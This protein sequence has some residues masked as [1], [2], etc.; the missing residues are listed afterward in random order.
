MKK[1]YW[2]T[3]TNFATITSGQ[4]SFDLTDYLKTFTENGLWT[5]AKYRTEYSD[6]FVKE[7]LEKIKSIKIHFYSSNFPYSNLHMYEGVIANYFDTKKITQAK[8][9]SSGISE[10]S[11]IA[12]LEIDF[13]SQ[14]KIINELTYEEEKN[15]DCV[16]ERLSDDNHD[17]WIEL[18]RIKSV[19]CEFIQFFT[20]NLHLNFLTHDY[21]FSFEEKSNPIGFTIVHENDEHHYSTDKIE[22]LSHYI[23]YDKESD[24]LK[25]LMDTTSKFWCTDFPSIHFFLD[26]LK[27]NYITSTNFVKLVFT[28]ESFFT[29]DLSNDFVSLTVSLVTSKDITEMKKIRET[30]RESFSL[31]NEIVHGNRLINMIDDSYDSDK[32]K[33]PDKLFFELKNIITKIFYFYINHNLFLRTQKV[34]INHELMFELLPNGLSF[35][36]KKK[37]K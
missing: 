26:A 18:R 3:S 9:I 30:I 35:D 31:R 6:K 34:K 33:R 5:K 7:D 27:G 12:V 15:V 1:F 20:F 11:K 36:K 10:A 37:Q 22:L 32:K 8:I 29:K 17:A 25:N 24:N 19:A 28:M 2:F 21:T 16:F 4:F 14:N 23:L 13:D